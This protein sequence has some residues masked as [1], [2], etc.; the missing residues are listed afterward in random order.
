MTH[1]CDSIIGD[2]NCLFRAVSK[3]ITGT[4]KNHRAM[5]LSIIRFMLEPLNALELTKMLFSTA[6]GPEGSPLMLITS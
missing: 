2:G 6:P 4:Q 3:E 1:V 5:C